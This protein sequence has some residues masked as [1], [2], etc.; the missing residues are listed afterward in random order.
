MFTAT[1]VS[2]DRVRSDLTLRNEL[3]IDGAWVRGSGEELTLVSPRDGQELT[4]IA[5]A[6][7]ADVDRAVAS[8]RSAFDS[9]VWS[10]LAPRDRGQRLIAFA[11]H[12]ADHA[13]ELALTITLE[14]GKPLR[15][16]YETELRAV[17]NSF[18]WYGEAIDKV[19]DETPSTAPDSL[20]LVTREPAG[21][22]GAV[23][24]WNFPL[25]MAAWK[26]APALAAG[27]SVVLKPD[28]HTSASALRLAEL[29]FE[30][31]IP[32]GVFNVV[33]GFGAVAGQA[34]G[35]HPDVDVITFTGSTAVGRK[36]LEYAAQSN[37]KRVW[38]ELGGKTASLVLDDADFVKAVEASAHGCFYNQGQMCTAASR[39]L[40]PR[41][42]LDEALEIAGR[43]AAL[44]RPADPLDLDAPMGS[45]VSRQHLDRVAGFVERAA[46]SGSD[47][48]AGGSEA[49]A[50]IEGGSYFAPVV[51]NATRESEIARQEVFGPVLSVIAFDSLDEAIEIANETEFGLAA[52]LWTTDL[53]NAHLVSRRLRAGIVW[54]NCFEEGDMTV[55][56]GGVKSSGFGRDK[57]LHAIDKFTD[58]KTTWIDLS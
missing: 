5:S 52:T 34:L 12:I 57:S 8:A 36:F 40:V 6:S 51:V 56:F 13:E 58:L 19:L 17:V 31:G 33:P 39:L 35:L 43:I 30:A 7:A 44:Q 37:G 2:W 9:G 24:P 55:P 53:K 32:A 38:P 50:V 29:A 41:H 16:A 20:A 26:L 15:Q 3:F 27:N 10:G 14:M 54:V 48:I 42:R 25:T 46:A 1:T 45:L 18:R 4:R 49:N 21:V 11:Q 28:E 23:V 47:L 22:V